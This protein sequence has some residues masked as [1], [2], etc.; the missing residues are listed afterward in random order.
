MRGPD[1]TIACLVGIGAAVVGFLV[2]LVVVAILLW[3]LR[4]LGAYI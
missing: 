2:A 3:S 1:W 4:Q